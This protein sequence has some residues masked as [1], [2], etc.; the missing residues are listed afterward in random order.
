MNL[1]KICHYFL[2]CLVAF[3]GFSQ[4]APALGFSRGAL[5]HVVTA[6]ALAKDSVG[7]AF[8]CLEVQLGSPD[9]SG[10]AVIRTPRFRTEV[11]VVPLNPVV[12]IE[13]PTLLSTPASTLW[14]SAWQARTYVTQALGRDLPRSAI[15]MAVN[16]VAGRSQDQFHIHVDC[17][18]QQVARS[19]SSLSPQIGE[20]WRRFPVPLAG[21]VYWARMVAS[22]DLAGVNVVNLLSKGLPNARN[23]M[24]RITVAVI[25]TELKDGREGFIALANSANSTAESLLDHSCKGTNVP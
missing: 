2:A 12:G 1:R 14:Q 17:V 5:G 13:D 9:T 24:E 20:S 22:T 7:V 18:K 15:G 8:P 19:I 11:L 6:C 4:A 23:A 10:Y 25:G 16:S 3:E 21:D